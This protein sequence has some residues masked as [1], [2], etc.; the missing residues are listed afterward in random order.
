MAFPT[1]SSDHQWQEQDLPSLSIAGRD[2]VA[3]IV[4]RLFRTRPLLL[5]LIVALGGVVCVYVIPFFDG[6]LLPRPAPYPRYYGSL[7]D[8]SDAIIWVILVPLAASMYLRQLTWI[9]SLFTNLYR[10]G[11]TG[12]TVDKY[13]QFVAEAQRAYNGW[14]WPVIAALVFLPFWI[15]FCIGVTRSPEFWYYPPA[16]W[17]WFLYISIEYLESYAAITTLIRYIVTSRQLRS[18]LKTGAFRGDAVL[19]PQFLHPDGLGGLGDILTLVRDGLLIGGGILI[20]VTLESINS[21]ATVAQSSQP[22]SLVSFIVIALAYGTI[23]PYF[24]LY[25]LRLALQS[26]QE[27][28]RYIATILSKYQNTVLWES[29]TDVH[30]PFPGGGFEH[31]EK[32]RLAV[33]VESMRPIWQIYQALDSLPGSILELSRRSSRMLLLTSI[34]PTIIAVAFRVVADIWGINWDAIIQGMLHVL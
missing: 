1:L 5:P 16:R 32:G 22:M 23:V 12:V 25:P 19:R 15:L 21:T 2:P 13:R 7:L 28:K 33:V 18:L 4:L 29:I 20:V 30:L 11:I 14:W 17:P 3:W 9:P 6:T 26:I 27:A 34:L 24:L 8:I 10:N 31:G